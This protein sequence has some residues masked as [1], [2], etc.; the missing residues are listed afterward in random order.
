MC[1]VRAHDVICQN[2]ACEGQQAVSWKAEPISSWNCKFAAWHEGLLC[3][4]EI[5]AG[6]LQKDVIKMTLDFML[7]QSTC[8]QGHLVLV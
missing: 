4:E 8:Q 5:A 6:D 3:S 7:E 1:G 2:N